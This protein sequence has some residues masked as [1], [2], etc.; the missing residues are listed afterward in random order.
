[1]DTAFVFPGQGSQAVGMLD[2]ICAASQSAAAC[3]EEA[4]DALGYDLGALISAGPDDVLGPTDV[5]QPAL[6]TTSVALYRA[7]IEAGGEAPTAMAGHSLGEYSALVCA[8]AIPFDKAVRL[9]R[10]RGELMQQAVPRGEG[11]MAAVL[12]LDDAAVEAACA[13]VDGVV[14]AANYNAPGQV[15]IAGAAD[16]VAA[17]IDACKAAGAKK[18]IP[19]PVSVPSHCQ[20]MSSAADSLAVA[21]A[22]I[23]LALPS[24]TLVHNVDATAAETLDAMR[25]ALINQLSEPVRWVDCVNALASGGVSRFVECGPGRVLSSMVKRIDRSLKPVSISDAD[26]LQSVLAAGNEE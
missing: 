7:W 14:S 15:V 19:L 23:D 1:M 12:G 17:A 20:L 3:V 13:T 18:A 16:A 26:T 5:T 6:L 9:V 22:D 8:G 25:A 21:L 2:S 10:H 24:V 4:N 11:A